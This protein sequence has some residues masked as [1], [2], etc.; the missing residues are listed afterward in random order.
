MDAADICTDRSEILSYSS[1]INRIAPVFFLV[2]DIFILAVFISSAGGRELAGLGGVTVVLAVALLVR[3]MTQGHYSRRITLATEVGQLVQGAFLASLI[4]AAAAYQIAGKVDWEWLGVHWVPLLACLV[5]GRQ[6]ARRLLVLGGLWDLP[7]LVVTAGSAE[8]LVAA[9]RSG[10]SLGYRVAG[11]VRVDDGS[12]T[13]AQIGRLCDGHSIQLAVLDPEAARGE[14]GKRLTR[15]L[16]G[17]HVDVA[18]ASSLAEMPVLGVRA[19]SFVSHDVV[20]LITRHGSGQAVLQMAKRGFDAAS[21]TLLLLALSPLLALLALAV[22]ADGGPA[23][24][25]H[26]RVGQNGTR[27]RCW[28]FRSMVPDADKV[29]GDLLASDPASA[30]EWRQHQKLKSDPR[31]TAIGRFLRGSSLDELPQLF[32]VLV[33]QMSLIGPRPVTE[34]E[35]DRYGEAK[36]Y[37]LAVRPGITGLWQVSGRNETSYRQRVLLDAWYVRNWSLWHDLL[38]LLKTIPVVLKRG[39]AY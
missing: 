9:V 32:N 17:R 25:G 37:Y 39:G 4:D 29:L 26:A 27:F 5:A 20:L 11:A 21:A 16:R 3:F 31:I 19:Q 30:E 15:A 10:A 2:P 14:S 6:V 18:L 8:P 12:E 24:F 34:A 38:I 7:V 28:K 13:E 23:L 1:Y 22:K 36:G 35:L 33:G